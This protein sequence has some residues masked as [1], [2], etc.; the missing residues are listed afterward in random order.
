ML[1]IHNSFK[2]KL[3]RMSKSSAMLFE[4][5]KNDNDELMQAIVNASQDTD[6]NWQLVERPDA[7]DLDEFWG[8]VV[9]DVQNDPDWQAM[10]ANE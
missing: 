2:L 7:A 4:P 3:P 1:K 6:D 9:K 10:H 8:N 5:V